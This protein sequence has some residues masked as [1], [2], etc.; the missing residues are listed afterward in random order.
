M[1]RLLPL[2]LLPGLLLPS[3]QRETTPTYPTADVA[4]VYTFMED[5]GTMDAATRASAY[6]RDSVEI[7]AFLRTV[8]ELSPDSS[9]MAA[10][11]ESKVVEVFTPAV[12]S[13]FGNGAAVGSALGAILAKAANEGIELP[14]RRYASV[15]Y[16][17]PESILF[18]DSVML[19]ALNHYLGADYPGYSHW[20]TYM[21]Q[22]KTPAM[23][24]YDMAEALTA[25]AYPYES[26][27]S[28]TLLSRLLYEGA[29]AHAKLRLVPDATPAMVL[30]YDDATMKWLAENENSLWQSIVSGRLLYDTAESTASKLV[31]PTPTVTLVTPNAPGRMGRYIGYRIV[32]DYMRSHPDATLPYL[33]S[34]SF[35]HSGS[36]L[37]ESGY[38]R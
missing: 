22:G 17:R 8:S 16:G 3:C 38:G 18:V 15:V 31:E 36:A 24:P 23:L 7:K 14:R 29:L 25:T 4:N 34:P 20:P 33:L 1:K 13:V 5:Y 32:E 27:E 21:R 37:V 10:W 19:I 11:A 2:I 9:L 35:Y 28:S 30:G 12:D 26:S 6:A